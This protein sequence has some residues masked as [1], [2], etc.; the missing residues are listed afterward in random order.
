MKASI[1]LVVVL[2]GAAIAMVARDP[3]AIIERVS[4]WIASLLM[5]STSIELD[6]LSLLL[7]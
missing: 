5:S 2:A 3:K 6:Y 7:F 4:E 1:A